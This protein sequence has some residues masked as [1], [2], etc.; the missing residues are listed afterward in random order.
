MSLSF[1]VNFGTFE[2]IQALS[3]WLIKNADFVSTHIQLFLAVLFVKKM[4]FEIL[5]RKTQNH[6]EDHK[7]ESASRNV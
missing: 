7:N 1:F 5:S 6:S 4:Q 2:A 3:S